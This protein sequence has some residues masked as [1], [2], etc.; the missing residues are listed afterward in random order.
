M[1]A[2]QVLGFA[3]VIVSLLI[4][5]V[6]VFASRGIVE[7]IHRQGSPGLRPQGGREEEAGER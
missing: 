4:L 1:N 3:I 5:A 2:E 7:R 6:L